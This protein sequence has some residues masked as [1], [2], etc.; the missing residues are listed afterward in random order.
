MTWTIKEEEIAKKEYEVFKEALFKNSEFSNEWKGYWEDRHDE[1]FGRKTVIK[2]DKKKYM[3]YW[4][5][6]RDIINDDNWDKI[7]KEEDYGDF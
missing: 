4:I 6:N 5:K 1:A 2:G 7:E 3:N